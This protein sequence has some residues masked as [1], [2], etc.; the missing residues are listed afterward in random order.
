MRLYIFKELY[1]SQD[2]WTKFVQNLSQNKA[3]A[4]VAGPKRKLYNLMFS[5]PKGKLGLRLP[6]AEARISKD[7]KTPIIAMPNHTTNR[8][9]HSSVCALLIPSQG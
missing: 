2:C 1:K 7:N 3:N 4:S 8:L 9:I 5:K 6:L